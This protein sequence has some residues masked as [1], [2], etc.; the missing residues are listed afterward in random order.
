MKRVVSDC[1]VIAKLFVPEPRSDVCA[2]QFEHWA[3]EGTEIWIPELAII[4]FANVLWRKVARG[5]LSRH[6]ARE[7]M[8]D[9]LMLPLHVAGHRD[10]AGASLRL[11]MELEITAYDACYVA[12]AHALKTTLVTADAK[13]AGKLKGG[14]VAAILIENS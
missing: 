12:V 9:F 11:A 4:E 1:S 5:E 14:P 8:A 10:L 7:S 6:L 2:G 13:L 3:R